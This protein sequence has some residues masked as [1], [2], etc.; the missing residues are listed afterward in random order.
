MRPSPEAQSELGSPRRL[1][2][3]LRRAFESSLRRLDAKVG[4]VGRRGVGATAA[5]RAAGATAHDNGARL[6]SCG[7]SGVA[8][9]VEVEIP[10]RARARARAEVD[11]SRARAP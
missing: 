3:R 11:F 5:R 10:G 8:A 4:F 1:F 7:C 2:T 6:V 9:E